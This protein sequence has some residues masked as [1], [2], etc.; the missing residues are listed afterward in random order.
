MSKILKIYMNYG[1]QVPIE[2]PDDWF[3]INVGD[4]YVVWTG[5]PP[6]QDIRIYTAHFVSGPDD[7]PIQWVEELGFALVG[8]QES[9]KILIKNHRNETQQW[10]EVIVT[11]AHDHRNLNCGGAPPGTTF[12]KFM[13]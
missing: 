12:D 1:Q 13:V 6:Y 9:C 11:P 3:D 5:L 2:D 4:P 10:I 8:V 7:G